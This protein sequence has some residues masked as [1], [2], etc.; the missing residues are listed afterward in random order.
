MSHAIMVAPALPRVPPV[1]LA[2]N[3]KRRQRPPAKTPNKDQNQNLPQ[4]PALGFGIKKKNPVWQCVQNCGACCKLDKGFEE[5]FEDPSD[6]EIQL[7]L[8]M[9]YDRTSWIISI[10]LYGA[11]A[12]NEESTR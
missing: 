9:D 4:N 6:I 5:I 11:R 8:C 12:H 10:V 2:A 3:R 1:S 7:K